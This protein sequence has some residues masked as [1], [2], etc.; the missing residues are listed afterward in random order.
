MC[1]KFLPNNGCLRKRHQLFLFIFV[2]SLLLAGFTPS[3]KAA[4]I[5]PGAEKALTCIVTNATSGA[6]VTNGIITKLPVI[7]F[8]VITVVIFAYMLVGAIQIFQAVRSGE[9]A[10]QFVVPVMS[11]FMGI[12]IIMVIQALLFP[13][14]TC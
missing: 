12:V 4:G 3:V 14:V 13:N 11:T 8:T 9:E 6:G 7:I 2:N 1:A 5:F 10:T